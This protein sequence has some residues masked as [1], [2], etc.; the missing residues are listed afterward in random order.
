[1]K[2]M[3]IGSGNLIV[4]KG[5]KFIREGKLNEGSKVVRLPNGVK[6]KIERCV[7]FNS[8][9]SLQFILSVNGFPNSFIFKTV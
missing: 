4:M 9:R 5:N 3:S 8:G 6:V 7:I 1:M 2:K